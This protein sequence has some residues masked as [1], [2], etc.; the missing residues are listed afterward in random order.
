MPSDQTTPTSI[1]APRLIRLLGS[2]TS[3]GV[4]EVGCYCATCRSSD[5]R[6][7]RTRTS[8]LVISAEGRRILFDCSPD[9]RQQAILS[10]IDRVDAIVLTHQHYDHVGGLDDLRTIAWD[11]EIQ[12]YAEPSVIDSIKAR[13][14]YYF[15]EHRYPGTPRLR[16]VPIESLD[17]FSI[18]DLEIQPIRVLHGRQPILGFRLGDFA[19]LTDAKTIAREELDK[20][21]GV[22]TLFINALRFFKPHPTH[23]TIE[24]AL[25][26]IDYLR[27]RQSFIIHLS[28]HVPPHAELQQMLPNGVFAGYDGL[29]LMRDSADEL[30]P[31]SEKPPLLKPIDSRDLPYR[32]IDCTRISYHDALE[33]QQ[34]AFDERV[35]AKAKHTG[36][37]VED[38]LL[39]CEHE[40]VFTI[41]KHGKEQNLLIP[42]Q[43]L[44][45]KGI[46]LVHIDRGGDIT[47]HGP[48]Q[49]T[50]Y[51][52]FDLEQ[53]GIGI[54]QYIHT[55]EQCIIDLLFLHGIRGE[56][57]DGATG[58]WIDPDTP[59]ARKICAIGVQVSR[60]ITM[61]G[62]A[63]NVNTDLSYF[64]LINPCGFTDKGVTSME[65]EL[66]TLVH[67]PLVKQQLEGLFRKHFYHLWLQ[68][69]ATNNNP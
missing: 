36:Q 26:Q 45:Q 40:P 55:M 11:R 59:H 5:P 61:H 20:L 69:H 47:Y 44:A 46:E 67:L 8:L 50:G 10:N 62:F 38:L 58:V 42:T 64:R 35:R 2:G 18:Y 19:F 63:L 43:L 65:Q 16:L 17:P 52:I 6:D 33:M 56:R 4:P 54:K 57:V 39:F 28:H 22:D 15:G 66:G 51:P 9:F 32:Y 49:I 24:D 3:T 12:I 29:T 41:G 34:R 48:G 37:L 23:Q 27:P 53:Y 13:L 60:Y 14:S 68:H 21:R 25:A 1:S 7:S 31:V 30:Q